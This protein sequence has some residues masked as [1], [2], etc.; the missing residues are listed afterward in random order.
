MSVFDYLGA[1]PKGDWAVSR[2]YAVLVFEKKARKEITEPSYPYDKY[3]FFYP[4]SPDYEPSSHSEGANGLM[5]NTAVSPPPHHATVPT[6]PDFPPDDQEEEDGDDEDAALMQLLQ[7]RA[8]AIALAGGQDAWDALSE[9]QM[10]FFLAKAADEGNG[11]KATPS[12]P[13]YPPPE[14]KF[15]PS[16]PDYPPPERK[17]EPSSP[18]YPPPESKFEPSRRG[19]GGLSS[20]ES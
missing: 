11:T 4:S 1:V 15:E 19:G 12:R 6:S 9:D 13:D 16:G 7:R 14:S 8:R 5:V 20:D 18:D 2:L 3:R 17:F 10:S